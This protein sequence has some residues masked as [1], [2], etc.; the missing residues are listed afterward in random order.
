LAIS[1]DHINQ[2]TD[3]LF[4]REAGKMVAVLTKIFGAENLEM[5]EDV[6]QDTL[7]A[8]L[9]KWPFG[10]I[11]QNPRAWLY[12]VARNKALDVLKSKRP[13]LKLDTDKEYNITDDALDALTLLSD[14]FDDRL[15]NDDVLNMMFACCSPGIAPK[16]QIALILKTLCGFTTMEIA[17]AFAVPEDTISKRL[18]RTKEFFR[19]NRPALQV[20][21]AGLSERLGVVLNAIYLLFNEGYSSTQSEE[22]IRHDLLFEAMRLCKLLTENKNTAS[23]ESNALM[24]L[25]CFHAARAESRLSPEGDII[26]LH[27]QDRSKWD[28]EL[29]QIGNYYM[30]CSAFG[31][32]ISPYHLEAGIAYEHCAAESFE[33][34]NWKQIISLYNNLLLIAPSPF[35]L[36][37]KAVAVLQLNGAETAL[38][39]LWDG[40]STA[41][42]KKMNSFYLY[43]AVL[44]DLY[45][46]LG[47][48]ELAATEYQQA[49]ALTA[50]AS[51]QKLLRNKLEV[52]GVKG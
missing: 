47:E 33:A 6:V 27:H 16:N 43:H 35:T 17:K 28:R 51:E 41:D 48:P 15:I 25:M 49:I 13:L 21:R 39:T 38:Q 45:Q 46:Q 30:N 1:P 22:L 52:V 26:L 18:Y 7:I 9:E 50:S 2:L 40:L 3:H 11:P 31:E 32:V 10:G 37:N 23:A 44:G 14:K 12:K 34:T 36:L 29:I 5:A 19:E 4:R 20:P 24:A 8:A 42:L